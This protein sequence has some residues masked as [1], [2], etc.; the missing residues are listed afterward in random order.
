[1]SVG[2]GKYGFQLST[3]CLPRN[4]H[5]PGGNLQRHAA[6]HDACELRLPSSEL[7]SLGEDRSRRPGFWLQRIQRY[8]SMHVLLSGV[9]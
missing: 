4:L 5:F 7:E 6:R 9:C 1:M 3:S 2:L 8:E